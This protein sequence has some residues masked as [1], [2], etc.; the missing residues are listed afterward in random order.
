VHVFLV[1][2]FNFSNEKQE[3]N[4]C[5]CL[6]TVLFFFTEQL[7]FYALFNVEEEGKEAVF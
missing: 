2:C 7:D 3:A 1:H 4:M 6:L 5:C